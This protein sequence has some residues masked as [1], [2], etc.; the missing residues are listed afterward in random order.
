V[1]AV[2]APTTSCQFY[3]E[4]KHQ[5]DSADNTNLILS[6][7]NQVFQEAGET[8]PTLKLTVNNQIP[9]GKAW[10]AVRRQLLPVYFWATTC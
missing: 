8:V 3:G 9:I 6:G 1:E 10:A 7:L 4:G 5:L 2:S